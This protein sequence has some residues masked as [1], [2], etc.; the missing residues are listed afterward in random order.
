MDGIT[1]ALL[2]DPVEVKSYFLNYLSVPY[3]FELTSRCFQT[4]DIQLNSKHEKNSACIRLLP[5]YVIEGRS[6]IR[7]SMGLQAVNL[8][9][10]CGIQ[11]YRLHTKLQREYTTFRDM[12][13]ILYRAIYLNKYYIAHV[14]LHYTYPYSTDFSRVQAYQIQTDLTILS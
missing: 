5:S 12:T 11:Q 10:D 7:V 1:Q 8:D 6:N 14:Q 3:Q 4:S 9:S 13:Y 2:S